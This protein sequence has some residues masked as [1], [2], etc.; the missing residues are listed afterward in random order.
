[1][2]AL[3]KYV[4]VSLVATAFLTP[5]ALAQSWRE[6]SFAGSNISAQF[7]AAPITA[8]SSYKLSNGLTVPAIVYSA[9]TENAVFS[10]TVADLSGTSSD[11]ERAVDDAV[12]AYGDSGEIKADVSE[13]IDR[14]QGR[15]LSV[16]GKDGSR[17]SVAIFFVGHHLYV[18]EGKALPPNAASGTANT[19]RFQQSFRFVGSY[20]IRGYAP[21]EDP[22]GAELGPGGPGF[23]PRGP[24]RRLGPPPRQAFDVCKIGRAHV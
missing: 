14:Q 9:R 17:S 12:K 6:Y 19:L 15:E 20:G 2:R 7:P 1:M 3:W 18:L 16:V 13:R 4:F 22:T 24:G 8:K 21:G 11:S 10:I 23:G 5:V